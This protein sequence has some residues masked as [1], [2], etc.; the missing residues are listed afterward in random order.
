MY[1]DSMKGLITRAVPK[2]R[3]TRVNETYT[4]PPIH[5]SLPLSIPSYLE[6]RRLAELPTDLMCI[7]ILIS[8][9][10]GLTRLIQ[11]LATEDSY[12]IQRKESSPCRFG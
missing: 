12:H 10:L 2:A 11:H 4:H 1:V 7:N 8:H 6:L 9:L 5:P 3:S